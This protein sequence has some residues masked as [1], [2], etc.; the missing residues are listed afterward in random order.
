MSIIRFAAIYAMVWLRHGVSFLERAEIK[1]VE[2]DPAHTG[3]GMSES[4]ALRPNWADILAEF[5]QG[6]SCL[7]NTSRNSPNNWS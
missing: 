6:M 7:W 5:L 2:P 1:P 4:I 3:E